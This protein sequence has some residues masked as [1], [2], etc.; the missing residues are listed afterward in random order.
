MNCRL[1]YLVGQLG[2]GGL[3]RQLFSLLQ[4]M[5][6]ARYRP[7]VVVW[8]FRVDD[9]FVP[10]IQNLAV[11]LHSFPPTLSGAGKL[12]A[13]RQLVMKMRPEVVH[14]Y[15][16][17][18]NFSAWWAT[19]G[20]RTIPIGAVRSNFVYD[21]KV[22]G[23]FWGNLSARWPDTQ[24]YNNFAGAEAARKSLGMFTPKQ[25]FVVWN[26]LDL[27]QLRSVPL[28]TNDQ[29]RILGV[30]SLL[31]VKRWDR[32][33]R[34]ALNLKKIGL[35]FYIQIAGGGPLRETLEQQAQDL[36]LTD[37]VRFI[38]HVNN[39]TA[40]LASSSFLVHTSDI[41]GCPNVVMEA[42]ACGRAVVATDAGDIPALVD[43]GKTGFV[44]HL[45]DEA[46]LVK[47][48]QTLIG[49]PSLCAQMGEAGRAKAERCFGLDRLV[50]ETFAV[51]KAAGWRDSILC[52]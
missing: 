36:G 18:T 52:A 29:V 27:E 40:L 30:G 51:Y 19:L 31:Q 22:S 21:K 16:F 44:V 28:S 37:R 7:E 46:T 9:T 25:I 47:R 12:H 3:E 5:D 34:A 10:Q 33:L 26:G 6:R 14:S 50:S 48:L 20:T 39:V 23:L 45:R 4:A 11:P 17:Y 41:E 13:F 15:S 2:P 8:N 35:N 49:N 38:G 43:D 42:M 1:L 32:L 24:V